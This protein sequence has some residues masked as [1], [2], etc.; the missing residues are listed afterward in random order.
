MHIESW[1]FELVFFSIF[2]LI[3]R[4][5]RII[6]GREVTSIF[7]WGSILWTGTIENLNVIMGGY[8]Y[9]AYAD[10]YTVADRVISGYGG[11]V[12][13]VLFVPL[14]ICLGWFVLSFPAF[15]IS[16]HFLGENR[17]IWLKATFAGLIL[18]SYDVMLDP[19]AVV[20]EWWRW[21]MPGFYFHGVP[22]GNW[23]G[24]FFLLFFF[25]AVFERTVIQRQGFGPLLKIE[26]RIFHTDTSN[27]ADMD[28]RR[29]GRVFYFR[30]IAFFPVFLVCLGIL[31]M[32]TTGLW[33]NRWKPF[34]NIFPDHPLLHKLFQIPPD[35]VS[36]ANQVPPYFEQIKQDR[37]EMRNE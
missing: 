6:Y 9:F 33:N 1:V 5:A 2:L 29:V 3:L 12:A 31:T 17:S 15:I 26:N 19:I 30:L 37:Q 4:E 22:I 28:I 34:N 24:W 14:T 13:W 8:D 27:M 32:A 20:N 35:G 10:Y 21:T 18:V 23:M 36:P 16:L 25:G 11:F 7:L